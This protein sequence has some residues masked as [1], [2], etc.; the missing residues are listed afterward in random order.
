MIHP[1][2]K[3]PRR[4]PAPI[5]IHPGGKH[6]R[7]GPA[8]IMIHP[9]VTRTSDNVALANIIPTLCVVS[10][11]CVVKTLAYESNSCAIHVT[12]SPGGRA[13]AYKNYTCAKERARVRGM[14][15]I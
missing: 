7:R 9:G 4:G 8:P 11:V 2:G 15:G 12:V 14:K 5:M 3:H 13:H 6:P 1:G 10:S